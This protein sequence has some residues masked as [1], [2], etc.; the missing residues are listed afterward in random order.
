MRPG[1]QLE[2]VTQKKGVKKLPFTQDC[3][4]TR[5]EPRATEMSSPHLEDIFESHRF[6][7]VS[8]LSELIP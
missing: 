8:E 2:L 7:R 6:N 5:P 3:V 4:E 1:S